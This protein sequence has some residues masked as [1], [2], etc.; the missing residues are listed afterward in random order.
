MR[1]KGFFAFTI[2]VLLILII[3]ELTVIKIDYYNKETNLAKEL[4]EIKDLSYTRSEFEYNIKNAIK[5]HLDNS[6]LTTQEQPILK[7]S[8]DY[9]VKQILNDYG[10]SYILISGL[11][12]TIFSCG[13]NT[14]AYY[15]Y[16]IILPISKDITKNNKT[17]KL[18]L[19]INYSIENTVVIP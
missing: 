14:C 4:I 18:K 5:I 10:F 8:I 2:C 11:L 7:D 3:I 15:K 12:I 19:P 9:L 17:I 6:I 13:I 1:N 16:S